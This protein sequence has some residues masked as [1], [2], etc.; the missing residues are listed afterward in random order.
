MY[1][2]VKNCREPYFIDDS[3]ISDVFIFVFELFVIFK[4]ILRHA[5]PGYAYECNTFINVLRSSKDFKRTV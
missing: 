2:I 4:I 5:K 1:F 3:R